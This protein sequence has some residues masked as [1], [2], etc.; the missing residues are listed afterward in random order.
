MEILAL[1]PAR[2][3]SKTVPRKNIRAIAGKPLIHWSIEMALY[4][5]LI[6]RC[7][8]STDD[9]EIADSAKLAGA[10]L[11]FMRPEHLSQDQTHDLPVFQHAI[12]WLAKYENYQPDIVIWLRPTSPLRVQQDIESII[13][14]LIQSKVD[15][16]RSVCEVEHHPYWMKKIENNRLRPL[17]A[18]HNEQQYYQRQ[19][20]PPVY[21]LNG[22]VEAIWTQTVETQR[23]L[24][25]HSVG[26][27]VM[28]AERSLEIDTA[29]DFLLVE[30]LLEERRKQYAPS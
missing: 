20:L 30:K 25:G 11:P 5:P 14:L 2:G 15:S 18:E 19:M 1:I 3:G 29:L 27:Y 24:Y 23:Q 7:I 26:S 21:R 10:E 8:V 9:H 12:E 17:L 16:V 4:C 6:Q 28:P 22:A 13:D